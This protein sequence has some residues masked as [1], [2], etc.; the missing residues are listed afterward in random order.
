[1]CSVESQLNSFHLRHIIFKWM[2]LA[3]TTRLLPVA[4]FLSSGVLLDPFSNRLS[5]HGWALEFLMSRAVPINDL[6]QLNRKR[7]LSKGSDCIET[8]HFKLIGLERDLKSF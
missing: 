3:D 4:I 2:K 6:K 7:L 5:E 1:M 8:Y